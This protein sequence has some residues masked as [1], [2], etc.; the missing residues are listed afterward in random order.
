MSGVTPDQLMT[1]AYVLLAVFAAIVTVDK[2]IDIF[3]KWR[4]PSTDTAKKLATDK[5]RLDEHE[6]SIDDLREGQQVLCSGIL[7]LLDH[8]LHNGNSDQMQDAR[9]GI[10]NY[11]SKKI[12]K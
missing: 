2:V 3:K 1:T 7:A 10:M 9:D 12:G 8:E 11:L 4:S 6:R 5:A